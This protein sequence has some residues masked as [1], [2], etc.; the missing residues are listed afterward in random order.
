MRVKPR[1]TASGRSPAIP[2][3]DSEPP[4]PCHSCHSEP[5]SPCHSNLLCHSEPPCHLVIPSLSR[6][7]KP[8]PCESTQPVRQATTS[9]RVGHGE[10][11]LAVVGLRFLGSARNDVAPLGMTLVIWLRAPLS[12]CHGSDL[13]CHSEPPCHL[14]IPTSP[15]IPSP[16]VICH[17]DLPCHSEPPCHLV[18][19][20]LSRNLKPLPCESTQPVRQAT[21]SGRVGHREAGLAVVGLRFL[22]SARNDMAPLGMTWL[23]SE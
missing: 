1:S 7:L 22:G 11:G 21:T 13:P 19:P 15:V 17:S 3:S 6:N 23:R 20:S 5:P 10:A 8:L 12:S 14:V 2:T 9:G 16:L 18:I 4:C